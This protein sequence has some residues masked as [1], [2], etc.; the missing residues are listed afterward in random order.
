MALWGRQVWGPWTNS[1]PFRCVRP[2]LGALKSNYLVPRATYQASPE[3]QSH[4]KSA[5]VSRLMST[6]RTNTVPS[7]SGVRIGPVGV[8]TEVGPRH[9]D[10]PRAAYVLRATVDELRAPNW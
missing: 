3:R 9:G 5:E 2:P 6:G 10:H 1:R 4:I 8:S 7:S